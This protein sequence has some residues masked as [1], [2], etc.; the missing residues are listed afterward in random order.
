MLRCGGFVA[1]DPTAFLPLHGTSA[2]RDRCGWMDE[3]RKCCI[4]VCAHVFCGAALGLLPGVALSGL[5]SISIPDR[6]VAALALSAIVGVGAGITGYMMLQIEA[7]QK[8]RQ[9]KG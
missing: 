3:T 7:A 6:S 4:L 8:S 1:S 2:A 5:V 9:L